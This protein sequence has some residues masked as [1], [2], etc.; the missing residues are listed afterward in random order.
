MKGSNPTN[1][2]VGVMIVAT[3]IS[4]FDDLFGAYHPER[5]YMRGPGPRWR[6]KHAART[7]ALRPNSQ[8]GFAKAA[9]YAAVLRRR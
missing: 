5:H 6:E 1:R 8:G 4:L 7:I 2:P 3:L 9:V